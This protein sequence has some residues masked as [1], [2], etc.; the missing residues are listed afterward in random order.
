M[1]YITVILGRGDDANQVSV[2]GQ[3]GPVDSLQ[4]DVLETRLLC[5]ILN[6]NTQT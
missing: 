4:V 1:S 3:L 2:E 5:R 6:L